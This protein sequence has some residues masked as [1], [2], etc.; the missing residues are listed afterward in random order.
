M[1]ISSL[2]TSLSFPIII[3]SAI[4]LYFLPPF[5]KQCISFVRHMYRIP[6]APGAYFL[7]GHIPLMYQIKREKKC[8]E[9][10]ALH[11]MI[12]GFLRDETIA[13]DGLFKVFFGPVPLVIVTS[14]EA[15]SPLLKSKT[16]PKSFIYK[17][18]DMAAIGLANLNGDKWKYHRK[19]LTPAFDYKMIQE[20]PSILTSNGHSLERELERNVMESGTIQNMGAL[21]SLYAL[22]VLLESAVGLND[23][24][25]SD[26]LQK[27]G[28]DVIEKL[29]ATFDESANILIERMLL[30]W[31]YFDSIFKM[32]KLG[33]RMVKLLGFMTG[34]VQQVLD[35][36]KQ[37]LAE[38]KSD[39]N[40][41]DN[42]ISSSNNNRKKKTTFIDILLKEQE[43]NP[44]QFTQQDV[45]GELRTFMAAGHETTA[46]TLTWF[47]FYV[48]HHPDVM[49]RI[50]E[51]I[52]S[53]YEQ[54]RGE[55]RGEGQ[56]ISL[57]DLRNMKYLEAAINESLRLTASVPMFS[58]TA[59]TDIT[60]N[61][62]YTIPKNSV[63]VIYP[64]FIH[65]NPNIWQDPGTYDPDRFYLQ[66]RHIP[67]SFIPFSAGHRVCIG[68]KYAMLSMLG[69][70]S[71]IF[72]K[73]NIQS[74][75]PM[76]QV[77]GSMNISFRPDQIL[78]LR[79]ERRC[80]D[81]SIHSP[82]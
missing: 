68:Q 29:E 59:D 10:Q 61:D 21:M 67:H 69:I 23:E 63:L 32:T 53:I 31:N 38:G 45:D 14:A 17:Y 26:I 13:K 51:E 20:L 25:M 70:T 44:S 27:N 48:G 72:R 65:R 35:R 46:T 40:H 81:S 39:P 56:E 74:L 19:L 3:L 54:A 73:F 64:Y 8:N 76:D 9:S 18:L 58:R 78:K 2:L 22:R 34:L 12:E 6:T 1:D 55:G 52:D 16:L 36:R 24:T 33:R 43:S 37:D 42:D 47:L 4:P 79:I 5:L 77:S 15:A 30:P 75:N 57:N 62:K 11:L 49:R 50:Q 7:L 66:N 80:L 60:I 41:N 28:S 82:A 71:V